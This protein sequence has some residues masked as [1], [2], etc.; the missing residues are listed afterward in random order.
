MKYNSKEDVRLFSLNIL[1]NILIYTSI[2]DL[3]YMVSVSRYYL[4]ILRG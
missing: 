3:L 2:F 4:L 1:Y